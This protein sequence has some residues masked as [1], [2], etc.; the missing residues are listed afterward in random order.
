MQCS[1]MISKKNDIIDHNRIEEHSK[2]SKYDKLH[3]KLVCNKTDLMM[4]LSFKT[5]VDSKGG[6]TKS[7]ICKE[8]MNR[9]R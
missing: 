5:R 3:L 8:E 4:S 2:C 1:T 6:K 7:S 9:K